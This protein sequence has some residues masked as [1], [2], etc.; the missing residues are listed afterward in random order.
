MDAGT[1]HLALSALGAAST[2]NAWRP[3]GRTGR[4]SG[5]SFPSGLVISE[6]PLHRLAV[7][8]AVTAGLARAGG[9]RGRM[10]RAGQ[11]LAA[12]SWAGL[13]A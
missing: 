9:L 10:R 3:L 5:L 11:A 2:W 7:H 13:A 1:A 6:L 12:A 8:A 4:A